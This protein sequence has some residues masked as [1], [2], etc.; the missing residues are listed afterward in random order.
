MPIVRRKT[1]EHAPRDEDETKRGDY[2][3]FL[4]VCVVAVGATTLSLA[5][6]PPRPPASLPSLRATDIGPVRTSTK[7]DRE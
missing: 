3:T 7:D 4:P 5:A 1:P 6:E 2:G